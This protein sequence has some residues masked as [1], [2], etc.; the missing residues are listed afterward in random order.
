MYAKH[1]NKASQFI[2][3]FVTIKVRHGQTLK[4]AITS[5]VE[6][7]LLAEVCESFAP[8]KSDIVLSKFTPKEKKFYTNHLKTCSLHKKNPRQKDFIVACV[9]QEV[10]LAQLMERE[11]A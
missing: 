8:Q 5:V 11:T 2:N 3:T 1:L 4:E 6:S 10:I 7:G 9:M